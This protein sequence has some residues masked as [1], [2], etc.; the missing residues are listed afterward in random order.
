M[1]VDTADGQAGELGEHTGQ[2]HGEANEP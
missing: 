2:R 1:E